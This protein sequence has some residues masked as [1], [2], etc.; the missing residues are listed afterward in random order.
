MGRFSGMEISSTRRMKKFSYLKTMAYSD[1]AFLYELTK[2]K[3]REIVVALV[4]KKSDFR[5]AH[6]EIRFLHRPCGNLISL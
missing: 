3:I 5:M 4:K 2:P 6:V 1:I